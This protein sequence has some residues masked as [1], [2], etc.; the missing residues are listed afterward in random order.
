MRLINA[1]FSVCRGQAFGGEE[2]G[3]AWRGKLKMGDKIKARE[4]NQSR[5]MEGRGG[6]A[7]PG[8]GPPFSRARAEGEYYSRGLFKA[9][10]TSSII[11]PSALFNLKCFAFKTGTMK[12]PVSGSAFA[13]R[14]FRAGT[15]TRQNWS[16][17]PRPPSLSGSYS[18]APASR[19][20]TEAQNK[21]FLLGGPRDWTA[22]CPGAAPSP[23][24]EGASPERERGC[25]QQAQGTLGQLCRRPPGR[26]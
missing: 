17:C 22:R 21:G 19:G 6:S 18:P 11:L 5:E 7:G 23:R 25:S 15:T 1:W 24:P 16:L 9:L 26:C 13:S 4:R 12:F 8:A 2:G 3:D 20:D 14:G 10:E